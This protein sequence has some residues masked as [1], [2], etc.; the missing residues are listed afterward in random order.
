MCG[1]KNRGKKIQL[2]FKI[3]WR[4]AAVAQMPWRENYSCKNS[5]AVA[6]RLKKVAHLAAARTK[7]SGVRPALDN[8]MYLVFK[9]FSFVIYHTCH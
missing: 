8:N 6:K 9:G 7:K 5:D 4:G 2:P 1:K 3:E